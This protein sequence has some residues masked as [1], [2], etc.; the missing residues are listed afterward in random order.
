MEALTST[1]KQNADNARQANELAGQRPSRWRSGGEVVG[2]VVDTM[3]AI[4]QSSSK[5]A[6]IIGVM[7]ASPSRPTSWPQ[8]GG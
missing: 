3:S 5:I 6:D 1:V 2:Q 8:C 7:T 4:H